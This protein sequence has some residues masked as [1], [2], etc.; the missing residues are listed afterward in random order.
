MRKFDTKVQHLKYKVLREVAKEA[1]NGTLTD[2]IL[3]IPQRIVPG[4]TP[5]MRCCIDK[6]R[7][8]LADRI[9]IA[10]GGDKNNPNVIEVI[11]NACDRCPT[12][13]YEVTNALLFCLALSV[14][15]F[16]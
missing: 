12:G 15:T 11:E 16:P 9:K 6:E 4:S 14:I 5:T 10:M 2:N 7:T 13:G 8:I 1:W 3:D